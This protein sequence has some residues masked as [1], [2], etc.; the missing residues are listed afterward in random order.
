MCCREGLYGHHVQGVY[1]SYSCVQLCFVFPAVH[2][3][4]G[5]NQSV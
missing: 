1:V 5:A 2:V 3:A 4:H